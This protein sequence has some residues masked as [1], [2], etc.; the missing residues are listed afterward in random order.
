MIQAVNNFVF[1]IRDETEKMSDGLI[2]PDQGTE[3]PNHGTIYSVG[4]NVQDKKIKTGK[5]CLFFKGNGFE[6]PYEGVDY[7]VLEAERVIGL[8]T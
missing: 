8:T 1:I 7:L 2:L 6:V 3:K 5:K 4:N